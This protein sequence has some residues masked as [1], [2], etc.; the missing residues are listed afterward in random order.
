[1][2]ELREGHRNDQCRGFQLRVRAPAWRRALLLCQGRRLQDSA[3]VGSALQYDIPSPGKVRQNVG[4][5]LE[6]RLRQVRGQKGA[7]ALQ[8]RQVVPGGAGQDEHRVR[9][10]DRLSGHQEAE[11]RLQGHDAGVPFRV[12]LMGH[13]PGLLPRH[14]SAPEAE[15]PERGPFHI[16]SGSQQHNGQDEEGLHK[17]LQDRQ[18]HGSPDRHRHGPCRP[19]ARRGACYTD[20]VA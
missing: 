14:D 17:G 19:E 6:D 11:E 7:V 16:Q 2:G 9:A 4:G 13:I 1:M 18:Q 15:R 20:E 5:R 10:C 8:V 3:Y 12:P